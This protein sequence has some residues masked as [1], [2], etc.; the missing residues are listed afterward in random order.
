MFASGLAFV[1]D[2]LVCSRRLLVLGSHIEVRL[3]LGS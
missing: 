3:K 2:T 1:H